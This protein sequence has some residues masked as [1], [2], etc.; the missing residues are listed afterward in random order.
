MRRVFWGFC[1]IWFFMSPL[2][3]L[4]GHSDFGF[5]FKEIFEK[6]LPAITDMGSRRLPVSLSRGFDDSPQLIR[7]V[8]DSLHHRYGEL[9]IEFFKR[10]LSVS[11]IWRV[12]ESPTPR[13]PDMESRRL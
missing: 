3:Y 13:I 8:T 6:R 2:H 11:M 5:K 7:G 1:R 9:A 10:K 4:P 12:G